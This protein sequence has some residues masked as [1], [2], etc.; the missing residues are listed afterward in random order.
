MRGDEGRVRMW[1]WGGVQCCV[2]QCGLARCGP[3]LWGLAFF[4]CT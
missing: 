3:N 4:V 1:G 2:G